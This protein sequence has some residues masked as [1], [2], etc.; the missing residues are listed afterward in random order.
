[1]PRDYKV[2]LE[3]IIEAVR[4]IRSYTEGLSREEF[5]ADSKTVD[6][7]VRNLEDL[8]CHGTRGAAAAPYVRRGPPWSDARMSQGGQG[9]ATAKQAALEVLNALPDDCTFGDIE[10]HLR[11]RQLIEE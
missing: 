2:Y 11:V 4:K 10:Y 1:M 9:M 6:A 8:P 5:L 7:I 3:D